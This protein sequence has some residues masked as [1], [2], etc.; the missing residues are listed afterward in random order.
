MTQESRWWDKLSIKRASLTW[1]TKK[2]IAS[3]W[4]PNKRCQERLLTPCLKPRN[5][6]KTNSKPTLKLFWTKVN[7]IKSLKS[8]QIL[9]NPKKNNSRLGNREKSQPK[10]KCTSTKCLPLNRKSM[11]FWTSRTK[12]TFA[13]RSSLLS[14]FSLVSTWPNFQTFSSTI[15]RNSWV[16]WPSDLFLP[17]PR[18]SYFSTM[19][20]DSKILKTFS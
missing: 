13:Q 14:L 12:D 16:E 19:A 20:K 4:L 6:F 3:K 17:T 8:P 10:I 11:F 1:S 15:G 7:R 18:L 2:E 9:K 5:S